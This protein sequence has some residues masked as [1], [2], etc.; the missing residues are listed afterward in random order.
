MD[1]RYELKWKVGV[2]AAETIAAKAREFSSAIA[3]LSRSGSWVK[4][5]V[6]SEWA[7]LESGASARLLIYG[8]DEE[9]ARDGLA[10]L[11]KRAVAPTKKRSKSSR[12]K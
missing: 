9:Q 1:I 11:L 12:A 4:A 6:A 7:G 2:A 10:A 3:L 8:K 5:T